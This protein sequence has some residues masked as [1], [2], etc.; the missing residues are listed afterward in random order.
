M[1]RLLLPSVKRCVIH[2]GTSYSASRLAEQMLQIEADERDVYEFFSKNAG[3]VPMPAEFPPVTPC[4]GM[5]SCL[6]PLVVDRCEM[7][8]LS[9][10]HVQAGARE[11][12]WLMHPVESEARHC[13]GRVPLW[14]TY[15]GS[16]FQKVHQKGPSRRHPSQAA[17]SYATATQLRLPRSLERP[18]LRGVLLAGP[19]R[20]LLFQLPLPQGFKGVSRAGCVW[21]SCSKAK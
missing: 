6:L 9:V 1:F 14:R 8:K 13:Q 16:T 4:H 2:G 18:R 11:G 10:M 21:D 17:M 12:L 20:F 3:K 7:C 5:L 19:S 15:A